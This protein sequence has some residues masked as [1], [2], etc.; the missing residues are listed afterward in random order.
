MQDLYYAIM[1]RAHEVYGDTL[2]DEVRVGLRLAM[3]GRTGEVVDGKY[4]QLDASLI[5]LMKSGG[6]VSGGRFGGVGFANYALPLGGRSGLPTYVRERPGIIAPQRRNALTRHYNALMGDQNDLAYYFMLPESSV[7][8]AF[9]HTST[10]FATAILGTTTVVGAADIGVP[11]AEIFG[12]GG[13]RNIDLGD[14]QRAISSI[15][16]LERSPLIGVGISM[17]AERGYPQ[18]IHPQIAAFLQNQCSLP[19]LRVPA[20]SDPFMGGT[21]E[22]SSEAFQARLTAAGAD[23]SQGLVGMVDANGEPVDLVALLGEDYIRSVRELNQSDIP[24]DIRSVAKT[25]RFYLPPGAMSLAFENSPLGELNRE[26]LKF[27]PTGP[28][29]LNLENLGPDTRERATWLG[30]AAWANRALVGV[31][32]IEFSP[33]KTAQQEEPARYKKTKKFY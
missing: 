18:R 16:D 11:G 33:T 25:E 13:A 5:D 32:V 31:D 21:L 17:Y 2:P 9:K 14:M 4:Y 29:T 20:K 28:A 26:L 19:V 12:G 22:E 27:F 10:M 15:I 6:L 3:T 7:E 24:I 23:P 1:V 8:T 30:K